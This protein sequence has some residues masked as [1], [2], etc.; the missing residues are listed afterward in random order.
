MATKD[1]IRPTAKGG[2]WL[3]VEEAASRMGV[4]EQHLHNQRAAKDPDRLK[5]YRLGKRVWYRESDVDRY[6][7]SCREK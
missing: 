1:L 5:G 4:T 3:T 6:V 2:P 7:E